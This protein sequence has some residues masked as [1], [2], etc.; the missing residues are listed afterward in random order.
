MPPYAT[1]LKRKRPS[2]IF[3]KRP[4]NKRWKVSSSTITKAIMRNTELR[5]SN[6]IEST[7]IS[8]TG[9]IKL[10]NGI[11]TGNDINQRAGR[12]IRLDSL[13]FQYRVTPAG[14]LNGY[15]YYQFWI[16]YDSAP[17]GVIPVFLDIFT[18]AS[19]QTAQRIDNMWRF[20]ILWHKTHGMNRNSTLLLNDNDAVYQKHNFSLSN[21][22]VQYKDVG[23][24]IGD[25]AK[26][27]L[28]LVMIGSNADADYVGNHN[29]RFKDI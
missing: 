2:K 20:K 6:V 16:I 7:A 3:S 23:T 27:A 14:A 4:S 17:N 10:L 26:G 22:L 29:V 11:G 1:G 15:G 28:Y 19:S 8:S 18:N 21:K 12:E 13:D 24:G 25:I 5:A 9:Y